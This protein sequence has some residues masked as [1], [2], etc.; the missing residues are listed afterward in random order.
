MRRA[1]ATV[2]CAMLT[3]SSAAVAQFKFVPATTDRDKL[4]CRSHLETG[5]LTREKKRCFA[6]KDWD[7]IIDSQQRGARK[8]VEDLTTRA[9]GG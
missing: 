2:V 1:I 6:Q 7:R 9:G 3:L 4:V 8:L 5:S